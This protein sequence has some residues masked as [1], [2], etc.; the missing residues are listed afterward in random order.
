MCVPCEFVRRSPAI[1]LR[2]F[3]C[4]NERMRSVN[5]MGHGKPSHALHEYKINFW[6]RKHITATRNEMHHRVR[7]RERVECEKLQRDRIDSQKRTQSELQTAFVR[8]TQFDGLPC[9][10]ALLSSLRSVHKHGGRMI[11]SI[12]Q[13]YFNEFFID[14]LVSSHLVPS[15]NNCADSS[16]T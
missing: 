9:T 5:G 8:M 11:G 4:E 16:A 2:V 6:A 13:V 7:W 15:A 12:W 10:M 1:R 14:S 3:V